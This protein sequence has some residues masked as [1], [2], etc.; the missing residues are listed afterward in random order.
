MKRREVIIKANQLSRAMD[1]KNVRVSY[2]KE[3][4][5]RKF[6]SISEILVFDK[7]MPETAKKYEEYQTEI[8]KIYESISKGKTKQV[9]GPGGQPSEI[10]DVDTSSP[11]FIK[12]KEAL[13]KKFADVIE[14]YKTKMEDYEKFLNEDYEEEIPVFM[15]DFD[16]LPADTSD[17]VMAAIEFM[18]REISIE[19]FNKK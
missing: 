11:E 5:R 18:V 2:A 8:R 19:E 15:V 4:N 13:D 17:I 16:E 7:V 3:K 12:K 9:P 1:I 14:D 10:F 6:Q